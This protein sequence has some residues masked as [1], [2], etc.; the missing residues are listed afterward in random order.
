MNWVGNEGFVRHHIY[1]DTSY[2][3]RAFYPQYDMI[4]VITDPGPSSF[5]TLKYGSFD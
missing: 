5:T 1:F 2:R 4:G 3:N